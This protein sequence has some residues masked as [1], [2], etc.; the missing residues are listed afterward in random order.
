MCCT[1][2][3]ATTPALSVRYMP[4]LCPRGR[5]LWRTSDRSLHRDGSRPST[6]WPTASMRQRTRRTRRL[7]QLAILTRKACLRLK[8]STMRSLLP[9]VEHRHTSRGNRGVQV[10]GGTRSER[11]AD[12]FPWS[13]RP[14]DSSYWYTGC[15]SDISSSIESPS[16]ATQP[17]VRREK[18]IIIC[19]SNVRLHRYGIGISENRSVKGI[20]FGKL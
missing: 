18:K 9:N 4:H 15:R 20:P 16:V 5:C 12:L 11:S 14:R 10:L 17:M 19:K 8:L 2:C 13:P 3:P 7:R 6:G 1:Y